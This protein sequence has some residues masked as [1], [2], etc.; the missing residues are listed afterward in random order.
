MDKDELA[1][2]RQVIESQLHFSQTELKRLSVLERL[3]AENAEAASKT[4]TKVAKAIPADKR[5]LVGQVLVKV[6][7]VDH[8]ITKSEF[9]ALERVFKTF[10]LPPQTLSELMLQVCPSPEE[11]TR[12]G[13]QT[14]SPGEAIPT[15]RGQPQ[16]FALDMSRVYA[17]TNETKEV[18]GILSVVMQDEKDETSPPSP[19][20]SRHPV[21]QHY[22]HRTASCDGGASPTADEF[23][24]LDPAFQP[25]LERLLARDSWPRTEFHALA[26]EFHLMP[27]SIQDV[28][29]E[30]ADESLGDFLLEG[31]D[32]V[33][34]RRELIQKEKT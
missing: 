9:R 22:D 34:I 11:A 4:L 5:M 29:N 13:G 25:V 18:V 15:G 3:L 27:L 12:S 24:G 31:E 2:F 28:I 1:V 26:S 7:A 33:V 32:P 6:A 17:I 30:W 14:G 21:R 19:E 8:V 23:I 16:G 20:A 10:E